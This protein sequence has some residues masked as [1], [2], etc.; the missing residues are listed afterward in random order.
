[1]HLTLEFSACQVIKVGTLFSYKRM[2]SE[3]EQSDEDCNWKII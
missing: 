3:E 1:M 2:I